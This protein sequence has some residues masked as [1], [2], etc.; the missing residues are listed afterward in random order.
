MEIP[1]ARLLATLA[2]GVCCG[3][4]LKKLRVPAGYLIGATS[5][6]CGAS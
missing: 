1:V 5:P 4:L 2:V 3:L 6:A